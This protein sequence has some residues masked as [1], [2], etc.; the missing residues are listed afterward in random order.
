M[1]T[2]EW[3]SFTAYPFNTLHWWQRLSEH[4][5]TRRLKKNQGLPRT[6]RN[7][8]ATRLIPGGP[9]SEDQPITDEDSFS[10]RRHG[11][12]VVLSLE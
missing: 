6:Y 11:I 3:K 7:H 8:Q 12:A 2:I 5:A 4:N 10:K 1:L 9:A